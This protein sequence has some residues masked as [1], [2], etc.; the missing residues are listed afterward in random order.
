M[1]NTKDVR[2]TLAAIRLKVEVQ[3]PLGQ[4]A[5]GK[6]VSSPS[7]MARCRAWE[8]V[9]TRGKWGG[10]VICRIPIRVLV[11]SLPG[12]KHFTEVTKLLQGC[13]HQASTLGE[14]I[15]WAE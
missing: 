10:V 11:L 8:R 5:G 4:V 14:Q 12:G 15:P 7:P 13:L 3:D 1:H 9:G 6:G 2:E